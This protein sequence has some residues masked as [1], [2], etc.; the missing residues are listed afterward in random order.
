MNSTLS[1]P[2]I[3]VVYDRLRPEE[4]MLFE[5]FEAQNIA[6]EKLYAPHIALDFS[7]TEGFRGFDVVLERCV[8]QTR[9]LAIS[10][11]FEALGTLVIN[12][13][14]VIEI[15]G[16]KLATNA[17]LC[18]DGV[19]A[20]RTGIAFEYDAVLKLCESFGFPVVLK[21]TVGSWGR[22]VSKI[23]DTDALEAILE[24][25]EVLGGHQHKV[26]YIQEY[27]KKPGRDIR[28][29]VVA[30]RVIAAIYRHSSHWITN[31]ARGGTAS[32]CPLYDDL[33]DITLR[34]AT[35]V[36]AGKSGGVVAVDLVESERGL[37]VVEVNHTM[38][39]RNSVITT[40]VDI[41]AEVAK[42]AASLVVPA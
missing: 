12:R 36:G 22:M 21:P 30:D 40:G 11:M 3:A 32:N 13:P 5:A 6:Y 38:E 9:G 23:N 7:Q 20:P 19:P 24:H 15:C 34:A 18:R 1:R 31:T 17:A 37:L 35:A 4:K 25:K 39:F 26:F 41:P 14:N 27:V 29:F 2:R 33:S 16:D 10:R 28:A 42:Y 8:S